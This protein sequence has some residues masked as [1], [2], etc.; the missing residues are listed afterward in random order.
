MIESLLSLIG[1]QHQSIRNHLFWATDAHEAT[2]FPILSVLILLHKVECKI[3]PNPVS[4]SC[5]I[6][7]HLWSY[8]NH[9][10]WQ[11]G[12]VLAEWVTSYFTIHLIQVGYK[13]LIRD[14]LVSDFSEEIIKL[15]LADLELIHYQLLC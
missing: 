5:K 14:F 9:E 3:E 6:F 10:R 11:I 4:I 2:N 15:R 7:F 13:W 12:H 8:Y 1:R